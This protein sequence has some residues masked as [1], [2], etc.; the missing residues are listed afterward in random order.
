[1]EP[2]AGKQYSPE[3]RT[4]KANAVLYCTVFL[5]VSIY[6]PLCSNKYHSFFC[7]S[8]AFSNWTRSSRYGRRQPFGIF[9]AFME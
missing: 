7:F 5:K 4:A 1:M 9:S 6:A 3:C 2:V 8:C